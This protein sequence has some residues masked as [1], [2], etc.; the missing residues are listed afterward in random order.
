MPYAR[1][2]LGQLY[3]RISATF[4]ARFPGADTN[5]R[6]SPDRA[7]Q[8]VIAASTDE[9]LAYLDWQAKQLFPF[10]ADTEYL[11]RWAAFKG[12]NRKP[13]TAGFGNL[14]LTGT[15]GYTAPAGTQLQTDDGSVTVALS[16][17]TVLGEDGTA[18]AMAQAQGGG[19]GTN[20]GVGT[21]LTFIGTPAGFADTAFVAT[22]FA[23]G[24]DA[25]SDAQL[26]LRTARAYAQP[27]F[28]GNEN[29]WQRAALAVLGVTRIFTSPATP[30]PGAVTIWPLF[31]GVR[32]NGIPAGTDAWYRPG[33]GPSAGIGGDGDQRVVLDAL[34]ATRPICAHV[35]VS[36]LATHAI[37]VTIANLANDT[38]ALRAAIDRELDSMYQRRATPGGKIWRSWISEAISRAAGEN[39]H[40]LNLPAGDTA[41][42]AGTIA[43]RGAMN[44]V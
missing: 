2:T 19:A 10:Q 15:P 33:T 9:D 16:I 28:G 12:I 17:D 22:T 40:D 1:P 18:E 23:G 31:D 11:E 24:A 42:A 4:R 43:I 25:E 34:L 6:F 3:D 38:P 14:T 27:S 20:I 29:D 5:L 35:Y 39:S 8:A 36:A 26:R 30:T 7:I 13:S 32:P 41:I 21:R 37:N 44:Y